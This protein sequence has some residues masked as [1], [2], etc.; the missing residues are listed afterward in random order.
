MKEAKAPLARIGDRSIGVITPGTDLM[1]DSADRSAQE[2]LLHG[3]SDT[4]RSI[5]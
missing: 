3:G 5:G 1:T 2:G 4:G